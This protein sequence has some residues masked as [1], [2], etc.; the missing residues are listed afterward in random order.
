MSALHTLGRMNVIQ[1][2]D[3]H[4]HVCVLPIQL[5]CALS[6]FGKLRG[7]GG[8]LARVAQHHNLQRMKVVARLRSGRMEQVSGNSPV[9][10]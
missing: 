6:V 2:H 9:Y 10:S 8:A 1:C 5:D 3:T 4:L 7:S